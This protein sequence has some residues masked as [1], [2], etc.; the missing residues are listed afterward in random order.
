VAEYFDFSPWAVRLLA[1]LL[2]FTL[3]PYLFVV[4]FILA[5]VLKDSPEQPFRDYGEEEFYNVYQSSRSDA[6]RKVNR[7][8]Q[9]LD[10]RIQRMEKIVTD[11]NYDL[12]EQYRKL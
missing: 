2:Q 3:V 12:E 9:T 5:F 11:R 4:Y 1:L 10:Q 8:F 7:A 6:L